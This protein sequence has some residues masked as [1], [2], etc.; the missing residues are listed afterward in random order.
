MQEFLFPDFGK[1]RTNSC[2]LLYILISYKPRLSHTFARAS[3]S[4]NCARS[5]GYPERFHCSFLLFWRKMSIPRTSP[6]R[7]PKSKQHARGHRHLWTDTIS[8]CIADD[9]RGTDVNWRSGIFHVF[10]TSGCLQAQLME[11]ASARA[12]STI[13]AFH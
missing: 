8:A 1:R 11:S 4:P 13:Q 9:R 6:W 7:F 3:H 10:M 5:G 2:S 12:Q